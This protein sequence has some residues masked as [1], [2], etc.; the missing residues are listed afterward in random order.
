ML[1]GDLDLADAAR[2]AAALAV[3]ASSGNQI[4]VDLA[5]LE[6]GRGSTLGPPASTCCWP[7][8]SSTCGGCLP[9][10]TCFMSSLSHAVQ[11]ASRTR[12]H[13]SARNRS[14]RSGV[15]PRWPMSSW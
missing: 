4:I 8:R 5:G 11:A 12:R 9:S 7:R 6:L 1:S 10:P 13:V 2:V 3:I 15:Q 14:Y